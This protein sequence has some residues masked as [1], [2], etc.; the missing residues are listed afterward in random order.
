MKCKLQSMNATKQTQIAEPLENLE[1]RCQ[2]PWA[3]LAFKPNIGRSCQESTQ[4][5]TNVITMQST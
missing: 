3:S 1:H 2:Q 5:P 4:L